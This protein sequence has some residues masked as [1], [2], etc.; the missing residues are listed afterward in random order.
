MVVRADGSQVT[1][2]EGLGDIKQGKRL[3]E[4]ARKLEDAGGSVEA[5]VGKIVILSAGGGLAVVGVGA[6]LVGG[7]LWLLSSQGALRGADS[8]V[9]NLGIQGPSI[10][11]SGVIAVA[12]G[13]FTVCAT[14]AM[15]IWQVVQ[16]APPP[17]PVNVS[18]LSNATTWSEKEAMEVVEA[19]NK[20]VDAQQGLPPASP[21]PQPYPEPQPSPEPAPLDAPPPAMPM[22]TDAPLS[23]PPVDA[24]PAMP[25]Q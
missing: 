22:V 16:G 25:P 15:W 17:D 19:H 6:G 20:A 18:N 24:P 5:L 1:V 9:A 4:R 21:G 8:R 10:L 11:V 3:I 12:I 2:G 14:A 13:M 7:V 23:P